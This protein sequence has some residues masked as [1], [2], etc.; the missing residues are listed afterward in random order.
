MRCAVDQVSSLCERTPVRFS[1]FLVSFIDRRRNRPLLGWSA[2]GR[3]VLQGAAIGLTCPA[4]AYRWKPRK[5][6]GLTGARHSANVPNRP[7]AASRPF[8]LA[9]AKRTLGVAPMHAS[10]ASCQKRTL[11]TQ[12]SAQKSHRSI[13]A[14]L[15]EIAIQ[16]ANHAVGTWPRAFAA[17]AANSPRPNAVPPIPQ[18]PSAASLRRTRCDWPSWIA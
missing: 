1:F 13:H 3:A 10:S 2:L 12:H 11:N 5:M 6:A 4:I 8:K 17:S 9:A 16:F 15:R 14:F 7:S 18:P